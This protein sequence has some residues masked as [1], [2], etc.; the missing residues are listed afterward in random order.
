[1]EKRLIHCVGLQFFAEGGSGGTGAAAAVTSA[2]SSVGESASTQPAAPEGANGRQAEH[3]SREP[4]IYRSERK[5]RRERRLHPERFTGDGD[6][7]MGRGKDE[8]TEATAT[9]A[10]D[11]SSD[12]SVEQPKDKRKAF[13]DMIHGEYKEEFTALFNERWNAKHRESRD[14]VEKLGKYEALTDKL[15]ARYDV[16]DTDA[17][18]KAFE[19]D[20][21]YWD[22]VAD[23]EGMTRAQYMDKL[24]KSIE[25]EKAKRENERLSRMA[26][27]RR[28]ADERSAETERRMR[29]AETLK[30]K[31][32]SFELDKELDNERFVRLLRAGISMEDAYAALHMAEIMDG[33]VRKTQAEAAKQVSDNIRSRG[34]RPTE[35]GMSASAGLVVA[36]GAKTREERAGLAERAKRG[37]TVRLR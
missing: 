33:A 23:A 4:I 1:M 27:E 34:L 25:L 35:N 2:E 26:D 36:K 31:Y 22:A 14:A 10:A 7:A 13:R 9:A 37:E 11:M 16:S 15:R 21:A 12:K 3:E 28:A 32:P 8:A 17:A 19:E 18:I 5:A 29:E 24:S 6:T 30:G 20:G